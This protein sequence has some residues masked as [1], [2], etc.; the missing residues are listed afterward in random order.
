MPPPRPCSH[1]LFGVCLP[2][3]RSPHNKHAAT[4]EPTR[5]GRCD[6]VQPLSRFRCCSVGV[7]SYCPVRVLRVVPFTFPCCPLRVFPVVPLA[8]LQLS[9]SRFTRC[10]VRVFRVSCCSVRVLLAAPFV[11]TLLFR[12]PFPCCPVRVFPVAPLAFS[13]L[14]FLRF[15]VVFSRRLP[16]GLG[17]PPR[18][19]WLSLGPPRPFLQ[20][21]YSGLGPDGPFAA[22]GMDKL[23][24]LHKSFSP[25][26]ARDPKATAL[27]WPWGRWLPVCSLRV[28]LPSLGPSARPF[29]LCGPWAYSATGIGKF[30][31]LYK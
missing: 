16:V 5:C 11:F 8:S 18:V 4:A 6:E 17:L 29:L 2:S 22:T 10:P 27:H 20:F 26:S 30:K 7:F 15:L 13:L 25:T 19:C 21:A 9:R 28:S 23:R 1:I 31:K 3:A 12:S 24:S 14:S